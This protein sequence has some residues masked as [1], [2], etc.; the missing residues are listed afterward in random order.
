MS[1]PRSLL[2][3]ESRRFIQAD[4]AFERLQRRRDRKRRN[5]RI[6]AGVLAL[7]IAIAVGWLEVNAIRSTPR[8]PADDR[9][10]DLG[11][12][13]P[14][15]GQIVYGNQP[16]VNRQGIWGVDPTAPGDPSGRVQLTSDRAEPRGWSSDGTELLIEANDPSKGVQLGHLSILH[17][18]GSVTPVTTDPMWILGA[19][20]S[21]DGS[22]VVF[23]GDT[24]EIP[25]CCTDKG[26]YAVDADGGP[27]EVLLEAQE[28]MVYE[29]TFSP[30]GTQIAYVTGGG[31]HTHHVWVIDADGSDAH[32]I[33]FNEWT[34]VGGHV[35]GLAWSPAGD[36]IAIGL[37]AI[38]TFAPDGSDF[39]RV[40][41]HGYF[42]YWS[43]DG[44]QIA[45]TI[46]WPFSTRGELAIADA[47]G[48]N[49]RMFGFAQSGPWHPAPIPPT[50]A[51]LSPDR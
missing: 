43:P 12:F 25:E 29:P 39:K 35:N 30:D 28:D 44:S 37:E 8:V 18:D 15:A 41:T 49:I 7:A 6:Q 34:N 24:G 9:S 19:T 1:D 14:V 33:V 10:E 17:A 42:P 4:G 27:A 38:Y 46:P 45:Y 22:R 31:D 3:R 32:E 23:A 5:Q 51:P 36:R 20:I 50:E 21:P 2:E 16:Y 48:S 11:I 47:D 40:I 26:L 13:A